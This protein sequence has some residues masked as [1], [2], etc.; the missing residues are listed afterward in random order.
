[1]IEIINDILRDETPERDATPEE[2]GLYTPVG[3][4]IQQLDNSEN[5]NGK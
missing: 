4:S 3:Q 5:L 2:L 1:M